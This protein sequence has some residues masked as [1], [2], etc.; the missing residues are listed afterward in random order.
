MFLSRSVVASAILIPTLVFADANPPQAPKKPHEITEVG[1]TRNDPFF[2]LRE[3]DNPEVLKYLEAES[4]YTESVLKHIGKLQEKEKDA[5]FFLELS[6][7]RNEKLIFVSVESDLSSEVRFLD[8]DRPDGEL[9]LIRPRENDLL[10]EV[11]NHGDR[12]FIV[13]NENAK[14]FKIIETPIA[15]PGKEHWKDFIPYDPEVEID[16]VDA[17]KAEDGVEIPISPVYKKGFK[18]D[19][20]APLLLESR[21]LPGPLQCRRSRDWGDVQSALWPFDPFVPIETTGASALGGLDR[22]T[23]PG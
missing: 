23:P 22:L 11:E 7:S 12:F 1:H 5:R 14:N 8:A 4:R 3:K 19:G 16:G 20:T 9:T 15:S 10:Y 17:F 18:K 6:K 2:W 21:T 13:T